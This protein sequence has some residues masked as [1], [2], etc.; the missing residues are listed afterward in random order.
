MDNVTA[1]ID[2]GCEFEGKL[3]FEGTVRIGGNFKGEIF[4]KDV[5]IVSEGSI[6]NAEIEASDVIINGEVNGNIKASGKVEIHSPGI[7]RGNIETPVL[8]IDEGVVFEG[9]TKMIG[10]KM[11]NGKKVS[12][13]KSS[14]IKK[15][16]N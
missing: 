3:T 9:S 11:V 8:S 15:V 4:T 1:I 13:M 16:S 10:K 12:F 14:G 2:K 6:I 5:L 7:L